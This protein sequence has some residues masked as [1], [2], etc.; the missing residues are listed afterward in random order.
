MSLGPLLASRQ[1]LGRAAKNAFHG[2]LVARHPC[3][4][5]PAQTATDPP[6]AT[7]FLST[8]TVKNRELALVWARVMMGLLRIRQMGVAPRRRNQINIT[9]TK[10]CQSAAEW[11][12][13]MARCLPQG[14]GNQ[15]P[16]DGLTAS[17]P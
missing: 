4:L 14:R 2:R 11:A 7:T 13:V 9:I 3:R 15:A 10:V 5:T 12:L 6:A 16:M 8:K 17:S 1:L